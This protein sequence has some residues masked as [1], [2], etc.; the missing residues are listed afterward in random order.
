M[1]IPKIS[2]EE[3]EARYKKIKPLVRDLTGT[4]HWIRRPDSLTNA[5]FTWDPVFL[6]EAVGLVPVETIKTLHAY[7]YYGVFKPSVQEVLAQV[8]S[9]LL[10]SV[11]AFSADGPRTSADLNRFR[12]ELNAGFHVALT[13]FYR[14]QSFFE[15]LLK[16]LHF[17]RKE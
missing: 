2:T 9:H 3:L 11:D 10:G 13:T 5:S 8:P 12:D 6:K 17:S 16:F 14:K 4:L 15:R 7:G 1:N